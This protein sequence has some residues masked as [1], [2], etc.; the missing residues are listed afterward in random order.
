MEAQRGAD[1]I[2]VMVCFPESERRSLGDLEQVRIRTQD[3][4]EVAFSRV[5]RAELSP[6]TLGISL[7]T[8][9]NRLHACGEL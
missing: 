1:D 4:V 8:L 7:K 9:Y 6:R 3:G 5:A 2:R